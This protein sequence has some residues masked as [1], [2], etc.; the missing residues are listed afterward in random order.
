MKIIYKDDT[1]SLYTVEP[2]IIRFTKSRSKHL[3]IDCF[4][5]RKLG[6]ILASSSSDEVAIHFDFPLI[7]AKVGNKIIHFDS[8][9][10]CEE[11]GKWLERD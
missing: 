7:F 10:R 2:K 4:D 5:L 1:K 6:R 8:D 11:A 9:L 3:K